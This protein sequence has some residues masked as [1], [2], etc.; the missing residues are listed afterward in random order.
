MKLGQPPSGRAV[1]ARPR[2]VVTPGQLH[3][4]RGLAALSAQAAGPEAR[5]LA[6]ARTPRAAAPPALSVGPAV[7]E[8]S[9]ADAAAEPSAP[10]VHFEAAGDTIA[11]G[12]RIAP[13]RAATA[14]QPQPQ[15]R[16]QPPAHRPRR[17][18]PRAVGSSA[19]V[20]RVDDD[21]IGG[22][23]TTAR[24]QTVATDRRA[25]RRPVGS[26]PPPGQQQHEQ[27]HRHSR[28]RLW[29]AANLLQLREDVTALG[30][31]DLRA[32]PAAGWASPLGSARGPPRCALEG[33]PATRRRWKHAGF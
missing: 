28:S 22:G 17:R 3:Q 31:S 16:P 6:L 5:E 26:P 13:G 32:R 27:Q 21:R 29:D 9:E 18:P 15:P 11:V 7:A 19:A 1:A 8:P 12:V 23:W 10:D 30:L 20:W 2:P 14:P 33:A 4:R 25:L 24:S